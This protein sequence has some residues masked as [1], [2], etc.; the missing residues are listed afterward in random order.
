MKKAFFLSI[1]CLFI[2]ACQQAPTWQDDSRVLA[3]VGEADI[4]EQMVA[5]YLSNQAVTE[6][7]EAQQAAALDAL[8]RQ[9]ALVNQAN[10]AGLELSVQQQQAIRKL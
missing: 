6:A 3:R 5:A 9:Q 2:S 10:K 7:T 4:T 8:V 1:T